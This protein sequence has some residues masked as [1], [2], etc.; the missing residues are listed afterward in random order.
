M[1]KLPKWLMKD[2]NAVTKNYIVVVPKNEFNKNTL[3]TLTNKLV[4][5]ESNSSFIPSQA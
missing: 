5:P 3:I 1:E 2:P 4:L